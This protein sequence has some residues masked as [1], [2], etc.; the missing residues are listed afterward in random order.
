MQAG[1]LIFVRQTGI[2]SDIIRAVD[3]GEFDHV[4]IAVDD[5]R[6]LEAQY[7]TKVHIIDN[8]YTDYEVVSLRLGDKARV[9][10]FAQLYL[11]KH[12]D[13]PEII[14]IFFR[15]ELGVNWLKKF[16]DD[17]AVVCSEL[18]GDYLEYVGIAKKGEELLAPNELY[19]SVKVLLGEKR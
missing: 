17:K 2:I 14:R 16:N 19:N 3:K 12:Y 1:D 5:K 8:P 4:A 10:E 18:T 15:I 7:N 6:I 13:F 9:E 11:G